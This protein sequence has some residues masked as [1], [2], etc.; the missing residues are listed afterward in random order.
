MINIK[1]FSSL[2][3]YVY[4][5]MP[6][7]IKYMPNIVY[8]RRQ[9]STRAFFSTMKSHNGIFEVDLKDSIQNPRNLNNDFYGSVFV[10]V[11]N[12]QATSVVIAIRGTAANIPGN[13]WADVHSWWK[14]VFDDSAHVNLPT[15]FTLMATRLC[16]RALCFALKS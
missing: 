4:R 16:H 6:N 11:Q 14:S 12:H 10:K 8:E 9:Y 5:D 13:D 7:I 2:A 1:E 15:Y 3:Y